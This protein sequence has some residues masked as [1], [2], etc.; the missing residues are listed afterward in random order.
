MTTGEATI[1]RLRGYYNFNDAV[2]DAVGEAAERQSHYPTYEDFL[3]DTLGEEMPVATKTYA[4]YLPAQIFD[5]RPKEHDPSELLEVHLPMANPLD[6]NMLYQL[7]TIAMVR[8]NTRIVATGRPAGGVYDQNQLT[9]PQR[10]LVAA[11]DMT[12][13]ID[14]MRKYTE[15]TGAERADHAAYSYGTLTAPEAIAQSDRPVGRAVLIEPVVKNYARGVGSLVGALRLGVAFKS[16]ESALQGYVEASGMPTFEEA[17]EDAISAGDYVKGLLLPTNIAV[18]RSLAR[19]LFGKKLASA[20]AAHPGMRD[21]LAW[22]S[23]S[24]F[25]L[26]SVMPQLCGPNSQAV[27]LEGQRHGLANDIHLQSAIVL[28]GLLR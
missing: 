27:R 11:G 13:V 9:R 19:G 17:R 4:G 20:R 2:L 14:P 24:E 5:H 12:P 3:I 22:G 15:G 28:E 7:G 23:E 16:T 26:D 21:T 6:T 25:D 1:E 8:P 10:K 18:A